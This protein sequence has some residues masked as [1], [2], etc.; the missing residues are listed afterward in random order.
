MR[1]AT[2][3]AGSTDRPGFTTIDAAARARVAGPGLRTFRAIADEW[4]L[5]ERQR[6][7]LL[8]EPPRSTYHQWMRRAADG[9]SVG[10]PLDTLLRMSGVLGIYKALAILFPKRDEGVAWLTG[11][12]AGPVFGGQAPLAVMVEGGPEGIIVVRR[13]LDAWRGGLHGAPAPSEAVEPVRP[14]DLV[15]V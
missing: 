2:A 1:I 11:P 9:E 4:R 7:A 10:L 5:T 15:F 13:Y 6:R 14:D 12:H 3:P 8:G